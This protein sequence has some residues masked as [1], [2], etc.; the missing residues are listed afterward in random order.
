MLLEEEMRRT[1][2]F[3]RWKAEWWGKQAPC[4][5]NIEAG[6]AEGLHAYAAEHEYLENALADR[7]ENKWR[8][9]RDRAKVVLEALASHELP[10]SFPDIHI[11]IELDDGR[12]D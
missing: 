3:G 10:E 5:S 7:L 8:D 6:L 11:D 1:I 9:V 2:V 12:E 4:R